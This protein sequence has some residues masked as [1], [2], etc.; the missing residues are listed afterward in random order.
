MKLSTRGRY[1]V[2]AMFDLACDRNGR[3]TTAAKI[4][5][6][7]KIS[8]VYLEQL[9]LKMKRKGLVKTVRGP[10]G[11]YLLAKQ[12][13]KISIGE[14]IEAVEGPIALASCMQTSFKCAKSGCCATKGLWIVLS[15]KIAKVLSSTTLADLCKGRV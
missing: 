15:R 2:T 6:R 7:Q 4:S 5:Q 14:I 10:R 12:P 8:L 13:S 9:L 11:G 3:L 1:A